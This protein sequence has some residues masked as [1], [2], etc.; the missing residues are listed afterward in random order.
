MKRILYTSG[1]DLPYW[2]IVVERFEIYAARCGAELVNLPKRAGDNP[3]W[4]LF[5][6][7]AHSLAQGE[8]VASLWV[9]ADIIIKL[10]ARDLFVYDRFMVC[11]PGTPQRVHPKWARAS[12][13]PK[14]GVPNMRPYPI[15]AVVGWRRRHVE[16]LCPWFEAGASESR[17]PGRGKT[18]NWWGDQE[19]LALGVYE[20]ELPFFFFPTPVHSMGARIRCEFAHAAGGT[21]NPARRKVPAL[22]KL[23]RRMEQWEMEDLRKS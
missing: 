11:E 19:V 3:Q 1:A 12:R 7:M 17:F 2:D 22:R 18:N 16:K 15:T 20:L 6:A 5:D 8:E 14:W 21:N 23:K 10:S 9:D 13:N 4:V